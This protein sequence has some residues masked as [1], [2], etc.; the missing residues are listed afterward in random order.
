MK[1]YFSL[2]I[3]FLVG[4]VGLHLP[5]SFAALYLLGASVVAIGFLRIRDVRIHEA[6]V[7]KPFWLF[8]VSLC[9][10]FSAFFSWGYLSWGFW[11]WPADSADVVNALF[12]PGLL[13]WSGLVLGAFYYRLNTFLLFAYAVCALAY[14]VAALVVSRSPWW[15][16]GQLFPSTLNVAWGSSIRLSVRSVEQNA[17]PGLLLIPAAIISLKSFKANFQWAIAVTFIVI[18]VI[19]AHSVISLN[20]RLGWAAL[21]FSLTPGL[22]QVK[23]PKNLLE[24]LRFLRVSGSRMWAAIVS[25][26]ILVSV[27]LFYLISKLFA[28]SIWKQGFCDERFDMFRQM[29]L[30]L[31]QELW[32]GRKLVVPYASC[33]DS[34]PLILAPENTSIDSVHNVFLEIYYSVGIVP[35]LLLLMFALPLFLR[36][37]NGFFRRPPFS[38][39]HN[40]IRWAL[41]CSLLV[42][43][44]F[45]PLLYSDGLTYY[46][47]FL[48]LGIL[49]SEFDLMVETNAKIP[50]NLH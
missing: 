43:W 15:N 26:M 50:Q 34:L 18:A 27:S 12:L 7:G 1:Q 45:Q 32:G 9:L 40:A 39:V 41:F 22:L 6:L 36:I 46:F 23:S 13:F 24:M 29:S 11:T 10:I 5:R 25:M 19:S 31:G 42:Q 49:A 16:V 44:L 37:V 33:G 21:L 8:S 14:V 30:R 3:L 48:V 38:S 4:Y 28:H 2:A 20:G 35:A 17:F 47:S